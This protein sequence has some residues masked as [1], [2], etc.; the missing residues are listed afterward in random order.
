M[1]GDI[2][3]CTRSAGTWTSSPGRCHRLRSRPG[4]RGAERHRAVTGEPAGRSPEPPRAGPRQRRRAR[5]PSQAA[6]ATRGQRGGRQLREAALAIRLTSTRKAR[7]G[8]SQRGSS[9]L[10]GLSRWNAMREQKGIKTWRIS[11]VGGKRHQDPEPGGKPLPGLTHTGL[12]FPTMLQGDL[13]ALG[14]S[15]FWAP[16]PSSLFQSAW[17]VTRPH[18]GCVGHLGHRAQVPGAVGRRGSHLAS[19]PT[20]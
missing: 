2:S 11:L 17:P 12:V 20:A 9:L 8:R 10:S 1:P 7:K 16:S 3:A 4:T 5:A 19:R 18:R 6:A 15:S 13:G 14:G